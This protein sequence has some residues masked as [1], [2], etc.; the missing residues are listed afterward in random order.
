V[1]ALHL[2]HELR[3]DDLGEGG[4]EEVAI[5]LFMESAAPLGDLDERDD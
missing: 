3:P 1:E 4:I 2:I 5:A